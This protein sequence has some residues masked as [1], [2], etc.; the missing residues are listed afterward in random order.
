ML[1]GRRGCPGCGHS[2]L[3]QVSVGITGRVG[4]VGRRPTGLRL[5]SHRLQR[6]IRLTQ[7]ADYAAPRVPSC[8][9]TPRIS[10]R[11]PTPA[12]L[13]LPLWTAA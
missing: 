10:V 1:C 6:D 8:P 13:P 5:H 12:L 2:L 4:E 3:V 9:A 11:V 7:K